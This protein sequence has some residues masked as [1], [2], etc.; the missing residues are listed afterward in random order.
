M[1]IAVM[2]TQGAV[3]VGFPTIIAM[4]LAYLRSQRRTY[5]EIN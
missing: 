4:M 5:S 1:A 2:A 3:I